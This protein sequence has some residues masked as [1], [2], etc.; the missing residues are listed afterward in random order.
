MENGRGPGDGAGRT[1]GSGSW[2]LT[3][4]GSWVAVGVVEGGD[5]ERE[6]KIGGKNFWGGKKMADAYS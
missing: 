3:V 4:P 6:G 2:R 5:G 1:G